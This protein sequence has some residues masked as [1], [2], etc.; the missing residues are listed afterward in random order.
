VIAQQQ[1][2]IDEEKIDVRLPS[3]FELLQNYP[4]P[5]NPSTTIAYKLPESAKVAL[6]VFSING[7]LVRTLVNSEMG[8]GLQTAIWD[9]RDESGRTVATGVYFY[10]IETRSNNGGQPFKQTLQMLFMK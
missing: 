1:E 7:Q 4:N 3:D 9:G 5:F 8:S 2:V 10:A 6:Q